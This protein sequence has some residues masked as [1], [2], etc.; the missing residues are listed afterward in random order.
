MTAPA[1]GTGTS[2]QPSA[3]I[4]TTQG[5]TTVGG[6]AY[7][8]TATIS[9]NAHRFL[10]TALG[11]IDASANASAEATA[12]QQLDAQLITGI[13]E[14]YTYNMSA[15]E[16]NALL[17]A[18]TV[19]DISA[20]DA[21][22]E[23]IALFVTFDGS[24][25]EWAVLKAALEHAVIN[26]TTVTA[27]ADLAANLK[28]ELLTQLLQWFTALG[29][30]DV[31]TVKQS[32]TLTS[33]SLV[34]DTSGGVD[35]MFSK[36][37]GLVPE[38]IYRQIPL[39]T[40]DGYNGGDDEPTVI[41]LPLNSLDILTFVFDVNCANMTM[42]MGG[43]ATA[44]I[45]QLG[46][47]SLLLA[48]NTVNGANVAVTRTTTTQSTTAGYAPS[49]SKMSWTPDSVRIA[50]D[51]VVDGAVTATPAVRTNINTHKRFA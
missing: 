36:M 23:Y 37:K 42:T 20:V 34:L 45:S 26:S 30:P 28:Q 1:T 25:N 35:N 10:C 24:G 22:G 16:S 41:S 11:V 18:F 49:Y 50:F 32:A 39:A 2:G 27:Q 47:D 4:T 7:Q 9:N 3:N 46:N 21:D 8:G 12:I 15:S 44:T 43:S 40:L 14:T 13:W 38:Q 5:V 29:S 6:G 33:C 51:L 17:N 48:T 19:T 31:N